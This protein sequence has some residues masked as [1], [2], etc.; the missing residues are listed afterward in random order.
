[1]L[2]DKEPSLSCPFPYSA[3]KYLM[4]TYYGTSTGEVLGALVSFMPAASEL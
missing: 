2:T 4:S 1:M 3:H